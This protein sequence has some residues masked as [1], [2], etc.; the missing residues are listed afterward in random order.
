MTRL[1]PIAIAAILHCGFTHAQTDCLRG[2]RNP[3]DMFPHATAQPA[4]APF[5]LKINEL[6]LGGVV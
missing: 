3:Q 5:L 1:F 6:P 2:F 4:A